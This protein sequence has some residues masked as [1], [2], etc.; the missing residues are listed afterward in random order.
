MKVILLENIK[1]LGNKYDVKNVKDGYARNFLFPK[2]LAKIAANI[3]I[4]ELEAQKAAQQKK[5]QEAK[6]QLESLAKE[7]AGREFCFT[8]KT[9]EKDEV[10][11]SVTKEDIK[12]SVSASVSNDNIEVNLEKPIKKLGEHQVEINLGGGIKT[13][14]KINV[15]AS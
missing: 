3:E 13:N 11:G 7:L 1:A 9:G 10:F 6:K 2:G 14:I 15:A 5:E 4:K 8:I 12:K